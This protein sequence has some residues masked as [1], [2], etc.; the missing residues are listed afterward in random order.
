MDREECSQM[1]QSEYCCEH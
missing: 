1:T